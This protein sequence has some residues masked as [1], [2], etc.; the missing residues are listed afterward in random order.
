MHIIKH[1]EGIWEVP[2][3][4]DARTCHELIN[5]SEV[6]GY[7]DAKV[8]THTIE[9]SMPMVRNNSKAIVE[10]S[11]VVETLAQGI[12]RIGLPRLNNRAVVGLPRS[13]R[14]YRY[15]PGQRFKMHKDGPWKE[16]GLI[17]EW[18]LLIYLNDEFE[19]GRTIFRDSA[20][21]VPKTGSALLFIHKTWHEGEEII[22]GTKYALRSDVLYENAP[23]G[24]CHS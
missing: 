10:W 21:I 2:N 17:S 7:Q 23:S 12:S 20:V 16:D 14:F 9:E 24:M 1:T 8:R 22:K 18:T 15:Q 3:F 11:E 19:G 13:L 5:R 6:F 4:M